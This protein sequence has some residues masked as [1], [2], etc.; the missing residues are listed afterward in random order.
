[1]S[2]LVE[3]VRRLGVPCEVA[4]SGRWV[5]LQPAGV[6]IV[7]YCWD[8][9]G[10]P[11]YLVLDDQAGCRR[12]PGLAE[13]LTAVLGCVGAHGGVTDGAVD[14]GAGDGRAVERSPAGHGD[15]PGPGR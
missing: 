12:Y 2:R 6:Y 10:W 13:A 1:M 3:M 8:E 7:E 4:L 14:S 15:R 9:D 5:R 11:Q